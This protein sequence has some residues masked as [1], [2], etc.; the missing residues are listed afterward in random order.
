MFGD[1]R[2][3]LLRPSALAVGPLTLLHA[4]DPTI[5]VVLEIG[6]TSETVTVT[7]EAPLLQSAE[8]TLGHQVS[9]S[10]LV[11]LPTNGRNAYGF[12]ALVPGVRAPVGFTQVSVKLAL[13]RLAPTRS[14]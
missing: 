5:P 1:D 4:K 7:A 3:G 13:E 9:N 8:A 2:L 10:T 14:V 11:N 6:E 12:A